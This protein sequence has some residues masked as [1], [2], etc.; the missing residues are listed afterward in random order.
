MSKN[1]IVF[2]DG[3]SNTKKT[4]TNV[5][6]FY[7]A[8]KDHP[9]NTCFYDRGVGSFGGD[10]L[11]KAFGAG[12]TTNIKQCYDFIVS[13][14]ESGDRL[15]LFGFSRGAYTVRSLASFVSLV[16]LVEKNTRKLGAHGPRHHKKQV[17][18]VQ[19][20]YARMA[21]DV[22]RTG[23]TPGFMAALREL[24]Q[25]QQMRE[26]HVFGLGVWDTVGAIGLPNRNRD[27]SAFG[28]HYYHQMTLPKNI[29][30]AYHALS[31][32][33]E[34]REFAPVLFSRVPINSGT[35]E[36][37]WF[38]GMH[39]DVGGGYKL[40]NKDPHAKE[41]SNISLKWMADKF[42]VVL[43][44]NRSEFGRGKPT[45]YMHDSLQGAAENLYVKRKRR[46]PKNSHLHQS[47][48][49]RIKGPIP[50]PSQTREPNGQYRPIALNATGF[51]VN[52]SS[53]PTFGLKRRYKI[54]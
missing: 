50:H 5:Y 38:P 54:V 9:E 18:T 10:I 24:K 44:F 48:V 29:A 47:V 4:N 27:Q 31:V 23:K 26:C 7:K 36:E 52:Y 49:K 22:Y 15:F 16:G 46:V 2:S 37:V 53:P 39:S 45:G 35:I 51:K 21:Y 11:G 13:R 6:Q 25:C 14:H 41:L 19:Q 34:R 12:L 3:T 42:S 17:L 8:L 1:V 28:D 33:D 30:H 43:K 32:D 40:K 20:K